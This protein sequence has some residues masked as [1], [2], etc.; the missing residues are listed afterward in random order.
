MPTG[1]P[2]QPSTV[3]REF[4]SVRQEPRGRRRWFESSAIELVLWLDDSGISTGFQLIYQLDGREC[5]LTWR[6]DFGFAHSRVDSG[7]HLLGK[8]TPLL[9]SDGAVPWAQVTDLF[10]QSAPSL[11][12]ELRDFILVRL[13]DRR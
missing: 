2:E 9:I 3:F 10:A 8:Q 11:E 6:R 13:C 7:D 1:A 12:P 4:K 5:A